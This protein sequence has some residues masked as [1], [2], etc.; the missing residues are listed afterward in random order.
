MMPEL[1]G[2]LS[3]CLLGTV[4][5][6]L[7]CEEPMGARISLVIGWG[8]ISLAIAL[9][10]SR[11]PPAVART[12]AIPINEVIAAAPPAVEACQG[13]EMLP[14]GTTAVRLSLEALLGPR[15]TVK[16]V[17]N[18]V[19]LSTGERAAGWSRQSVTVPIRALRHSVAGVS[20]CFAVAARDETVKV[21]G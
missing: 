20:L 2:H 10:M 19:V 12:N 5:D 3:L 4:L 9:V 7:D 8:L 18:G 14:S 21:K 13:N 15:V 1:A 17:R 11:S 6:C 16:I